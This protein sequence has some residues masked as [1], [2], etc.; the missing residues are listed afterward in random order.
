MNPD[1]PPAAFADLWNT[2]NT[3]QPWMGVVKNRCKN[4]DFY[5][6]DAYVTPQHENGK[7]VGYQSVRTRPDAAARSRAEKLYQ[8]INANRRVM[9][10]W[11]R[12]GT[13]ALGFSAR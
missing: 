8:R 13:R 7:V 9:G 6:V 10:L 5:W 2:L 3:G 11:T 4:G 1:M 12:V